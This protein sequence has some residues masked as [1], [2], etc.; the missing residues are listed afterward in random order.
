MLICILVYILV[1]S[2][3]YTSIRMFYDWLKITQDFGFDLPLVSD[4]AYQNIE[5]ETG[6]A[7]KVVQPR[8]QHH[9]SFSTSVSIQISG[10]RLTM[11]GNPSRF[12]R[13]DN[14]YGLTSLDQCVEVFNAIN[15]QLG[16]PLF[17][18][19]TKRF[20]RQSE[21]GTKTSVC[22]DGAVIQ[23]IDITDNYCTGGYSRD[24]LRG[25]STLRYKNSIPR[26]HTNGFGVDWLSPKG[27]AYLQ[28]S[29]CYDKANELKLRTLPKAKRNFGSDSEEYAYLLKL[30]ELLDQNGV[31]R[32]EQELHSAF[33]RKHEFRFWGLFD[34]SELRQH[35]DNFIHLDTRLQVPQ[36]NILSIAEKLI[37]QGICPNT[38]AANTT[39][40]YAF[41]WMHGQKF[42]LS[43]SNVQKHRARLRKIGIDIA[44][45][46]DT[47][48]F[49]PVFVERSKH[50]NVTPLIMPDWYQA[51]TTKPAL[52]A[53]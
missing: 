19:C 8:F 17:T 49:T 36:M 44:D 22:S 30:V 31:I 46:Y 35:H 14:V 28:Y 48:K 20:H 10:S 5:V 4:R 43:Q 2:Y 23:R 18:K 6:L 21:D 39:A 11:E 27:N 12:N 32:F 45:E 42:N 33:L 34:E 53:A 9:G 29:K 25:L 15:S 40:N 1:T 26:L 7:G 13:L 3:M 47:H 41:L 52:R 24:Y 16:L 51:P 50:I 38:K 37:E